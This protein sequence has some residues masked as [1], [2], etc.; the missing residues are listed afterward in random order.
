M[1]NTEHKRVTTADLG[2]K[3][4]LTIPSSCIIKAPV[5]INFRGVGREE[6]VFK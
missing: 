3:L 1:T 2:N 6:G 5:L 4:G